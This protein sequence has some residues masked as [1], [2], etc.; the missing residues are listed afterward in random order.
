MFSAMISLTTVTTGTILLILSP[1]IDACI[2]DVMVVR[3][4][5]IIMI[6]VIRTVTILIPCYGFGK[7]SNPISPPTLNP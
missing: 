2:G 4:R 6:T 3:T 1:S 7:A 5:I